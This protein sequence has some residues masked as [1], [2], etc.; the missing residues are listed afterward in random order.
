MKLIETKA[1][2]GASFTYGTSTSVETTVSHTYSA[3]GGEEVVLFSCIPV[4]V[5]TYKVLRSPNQASIG[6]EVTVNVPRK[7]QI[8]S[9]SRD[10]YNALPE[11]PAPIGD[12]VL[13]YTI[14]VPSSYPTKDS[15]TNLVNSSGGGLMDK[16]GL[17]TGDSQG[18]NTTTVEQST[19]K[20]NTYGAGFSYQVEQTNVVSGVL[21]G[22]SYGFEG[23]LDYGFSTGT[24]TTIEGVVPNTTGTNPSFQYGIGSY[25]KKID[26]QEQPFVVVTYWV[27]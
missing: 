26:A 18:A 13:G 2:F 10:K 12:D 7:P 23:S 5:Y 8:V 17:F 15:I 21:W 19:T 1:T 20:E 14:G 6:T 27:Q 22:I 9:M 24:G 16:E 25:Q 11:L 4:D 3:I